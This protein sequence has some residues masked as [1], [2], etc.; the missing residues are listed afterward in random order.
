M[1][2][3]HHSKRCRLRYGNDYNDQYGFKGTS[4]LGT[5]ISSMTRLWSPKKLK[6]TKRRR[7]ISR[8]SRKE[9]K[10]RGNFFK[11]KK[12]RKMCSISPDCVDAQK[13]IYT[14]HE[15]ERRENECKEKSGYSFKGT[16]R[17]SKKG[18]APPADQNKKHRKS[19]FFKRKIKRNDSTI[20]QSFGIDAPQKS[21]TPPIQ[22]EYRKSP[23]TKYSMNNK[24]D[25]NNGS[26]E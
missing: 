5:E 16:N 9:R 17:S 20:I 10:G 2:T 25:K 18:K 7:Q 8:H 6:F 1:P 15:Y 26:W 22:S 11:K 24:C 13:Q 21:N 12:I 4:P 23:S 14:E 3:I 19:I